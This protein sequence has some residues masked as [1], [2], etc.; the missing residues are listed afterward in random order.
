MEVL[1]AI[2][3][4]SSPLSLGV[5]PLTD[6]MVQ[7]LIEAAVRA[8]DH[9]RMTPW[10]FVVIAGDARKR[11]GAAMRDSLARRDPAAS[12]AALDGEAAKALRAPT[13]I[14]VAARIG[15]GKIPPAEQV[16]AVAA[17]VQNMILAAEAL[18]LGAMWKTGAAARD[19]AVKQAL[20]LLA[21]D[22]IV[23]LLYL[24]TPERTK[25]PR[26]VETAG[27]WWSL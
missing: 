3:R 20:G 15:E 26:S 9:G 1:E 22:E 5:A 2:A 14:V 18:G 10:R 23:A 6:E 11:L 27:L 25:P 13:I 4:R 24:G 7:T 8:P 12:E 16:M 19:A 21:D 17:G